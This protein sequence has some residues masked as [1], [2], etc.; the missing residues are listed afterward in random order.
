MVS[1]GTFHLNQMKGGT[2][3]LLLYGVNSCVRLHLA[4]LTHLV[5][6]KEGK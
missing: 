6:G 3:I 4:E 2:S 1:S 5:N